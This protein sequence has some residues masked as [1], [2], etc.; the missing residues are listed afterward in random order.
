MLKGTNATSIL[1][2]AEAW[3][4]LLHKTRVS[5]WPWSASL[6]EQASQWKMTPEELFKEISEHDVKPTG[7]WKWWTEPRQYATKRRWLGWYFLN[8]A[9]NRLSQAQSPSEVHYLKMMFQPYLS[10][11]LQGLYHSWIQLARVLFQVWG[12]VETKPAALA[13]SYPDIPHYDE[14]YLTRVRCCAF[15]GMGKDPQSVTLAE[16]R[17]QQ[18]IL[19]DYCLV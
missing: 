14:V 9:F 8:T 18:K 13:P 12:L 4:S 19:S 16:L 15:L 6:A 11:W 1:A 17:Q 7:F 3:E 2:S 10:Q 5:W